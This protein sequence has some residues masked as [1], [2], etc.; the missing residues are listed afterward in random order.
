MASEI[1]AP[2]KQDSLIFC[3]DDEEL[4]FAVFDARM[5]AETTGYDYTG[6][7]GIHRRSNSLKI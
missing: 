5:A 7:S 6:N 2:M 1:E 4:E 3:A